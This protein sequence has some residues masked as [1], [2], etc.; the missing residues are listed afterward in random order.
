[1]AP[2]EVRSDLSFLTRARTCGAIALLAAFGVAAGGCAM[3]PA[4]GRN[5]LMLVSESQE[6]AM[7]R[8][9]D[10]AVIASIGLYPDAAWQRYIQ[11]FGARLAAT[12]ESPDLPWTFRVVDDPAVNA[13]A[14][15]GGFIYV[16]RGLLAHLTS[17]AELASVVGH[18]IGHVT[19]R[20]TAAEMSKQQLMGLGLAVGSMASSQVAQ[21]AGLAN[22]ALGIL[23]LKFSRDDESQADELGLRY[24][25]RANY[26]PRQM[27]AVFHMLERLSAAGGG[28]RLPTWL[29]THPTPENRFATMSEEIAALPQNFSG[30]VVNRDSY[31]RRLDGQVFGE[32]PREGYFKGSQYFHPD[33]R[34][35]LTLPE[36]WATHNG[37]QA[38]VAVSPGKDAV[39]ELSLAQ[40]TSAAAAARVFLA[41]QGITGGTMSRASLG[42]LPTVSASFGAATQDGTLRGMVLFVEHRGAVFGLIGYAPEARWPTYQVAAERALRSFMPLTDSRALNV[43]PQ[44]LDIVKLDRR[45]TIEA[46][47]RQRSSPA[48]AA[49]LALINQVELQTP[50]EPGRVIK[51]VVGQP[52]P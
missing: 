21:Y 3:N 47:A 17:E 52:L 25:R 2:N 34:F 50:L 51:W 16:T 28:G 38:V 18:E 33:M 49:T 8:Q 40:E 23:Y 5:Q 12:S 4:T 27:P 20:H 42:G 7:G 22:Q 35:Q 44:R 45:T 48:S 30:T 1:M 31:L 32:N 24:M 14:L 10:T 26:D 11:Q 13:F 19:A 46:L 6:I 41:Q 37:K 39:V 29:A 9:A 15:P 43:Q 36:G